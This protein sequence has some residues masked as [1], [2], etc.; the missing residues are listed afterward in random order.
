MAHFWNDTK[1]ASRQDIIKAV[2]ADWI[3]VASV[4]HPNASAADVDA[5]AAVLAKTVERYAKIV[6]FQNKEYRRAFPKRVRR[7][8][9]FRPWRGSNGSQL[10]VEISET[11]F[12]TFRMHALR[13]NAARW[14]DGRTMADKIDE[15]AADDGRRC[16]LKGL[17]LTN[18]GKRDDRAI[19]RLFAACKFPVFVRNSERAFATWC[20]GFDTVCDEYAGR[21]AGLPQY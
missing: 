5:A 13:F 8:A 18:T 14:E 19:R 6:E 3:G 21:R 1:N 4:T 12:R 15:I 7:V 10:A 16:A 2:H 17:G 11:N 9:R 20:E